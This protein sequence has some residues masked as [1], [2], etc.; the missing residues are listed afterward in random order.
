MFNKVFNRGRG[1]AT[2]INYLVSTHD[3]TGKPRTPP[4]EV[5]RG[6]ISI[7][8]GL[9]ASLRYTQRY[10]S[11]VLSWSE[12]PESISQE[13]MDQVMDSFENMVCAG[14]PTDRLNFLWVKHQDKGRLELHYVIPNVD[15]LTGKR[16]APYFDRVDRALFRAWERLTNATFGFSNPADSSLKRNTKMPP[17]LPADKTIALT[18]INGRINILV[19][20]GQIK[21]RADVINELQSIGFT[22]TRTGK[23]YL[24]IKDSTGR[25]L[26]LRGGLF[27]EVFQM[28]AELSNSPGALYD[29]S[30]LQVAFDTQLEKRSQYIES[31]FKRP[32]QKIAGDHNDE[33][34]IF[35]ENFDE[36]IKTAGSSIDREYRANTTKPL[37]RLAIA[38]R[39]IAESIELFINYARELIKR[40]GQPQAV[41]AERPFNPN[42]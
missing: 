34:R 40:I 41:A 14:L 2:G 17:F 27:E 25:K 32:I 30:A 37:P 13:Q 18:Q 5:I 3:A 1:K 7:T 28:P 9:I 38:T 20:A 36:G 16:F 39:S 6:D 26:R 24:S 42:H 12:S 21:S 10:T 29:V 19:R 4:A 22:I 35:K 33:D 15:L 31:R 23:D 8:K 11:G